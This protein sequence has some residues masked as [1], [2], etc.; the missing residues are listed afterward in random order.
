MEDA[1]ACYIE[2]LKEDLGYAGVRVAR[3]AWGYGEEDGGFI[4]GAAELEVVEEDVFPMMR[5]LAT[6]VLGC[7]E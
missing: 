6:Y 4:L 1:E 7:I 5:S 2:S 3:Q